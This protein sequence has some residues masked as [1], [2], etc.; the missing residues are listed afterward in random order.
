MS[1]SCLCSNVLSC[2][3]YSLPL[4]IQT[5]GATDW[6]MFRIGDRY[7]LAVANG[8]MLYDRRP[9]L[10]AINSTIYELDM[11]TQMFITFQNIGT[12]R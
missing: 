5:L 9:S 8:H 10:Y 2:F 7:F 12:Y 3:N 1:C 11:V 4:S 6:E